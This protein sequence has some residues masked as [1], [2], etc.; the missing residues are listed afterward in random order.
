MCSQVWLCI[1]SPN[2]DFYCLPTKNLNTSAQAL[3]AA[4]QQEIKPKKI[5]RNLNDILRGG[6]A[7]QFDST[8]FQK[9]NIHINSYI[10]LQLCSYQLNMSNI[11]YGKYITHNKSDTYSAIQ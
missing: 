1:F 4:Y 8:S 2:L 10:I 3:T 9:H 11:T 6:T 7:H 5:C